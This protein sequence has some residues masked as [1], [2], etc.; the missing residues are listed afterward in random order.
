[1]NLI[2]KYFV[3]AVCF[4]ALTACAPQNLEDLKDYKHNFKEENIN[5]F[6]KSFSDHR[7]GQALLKPTGSDILYA[8]KPQSLTNGQMLPLLGYY[9]YNALDFED[10]KSKKSIGIDV[11]LRDVD[12]SIRFGSLPN[13]RLG[14]YSAGVQARV[15][16]RDM[17]KNE[18]IDTFPILLAEKQI[19]TS[20]TG[21][22]PEPST[23]AY[24][25][26]A[27]LDDVSFDLGRE[28]LSQV[29]DIVDDYYTYEENSKEED[30]EDKLTDTIKDVSPLDKVKEVSLDSIEEKDLK[31][32][33]KMLKYIEEEEQK[34]L[35]RK[36]E[37]RKLFEHKLKEQKHLDFLDSE[38]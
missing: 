14:Y 27:L 17:V 6:L 9:L 24:T 3:L 26:L 25:L 35:E 15:I 29:D 13:G 5:V 37:Q 18:V 38:Q 2:K 4:S 22:A 7:Q 30:F 31:V 28:I 21:R 1:M 23:D 19:R 34:L 33:P 8:Y 20:S 36:E 32:D 10:S 16:V 11:S 12:T